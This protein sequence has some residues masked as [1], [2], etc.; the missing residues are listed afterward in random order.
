MHDGAWRSVAGQS[1]ATR[2]GDE[3][4]L[5]TWQSL[6]SF[7]FMVAM[8]PWRWRSRASLRPDG[9]DGC[10]GLDWTA[11]T[12]GGDSQTGWPAP[13]LLICVPLGN[14]ERPALPRPARP[15]PC[16]G[17]AL[18]W[19]CFRTLLPEPI[20]RCSSSGLEQMDEKNN[21]NVLTIFYRENSYIIAIFPSRIYW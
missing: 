4:I 13:L 6:T 8:P 21:L 19:R 17:P 15:W 20:P 16:H 12:P 18:L 3:I 2:R 5:N 11:R 1:K 10:V 14:G 9:C 7:A